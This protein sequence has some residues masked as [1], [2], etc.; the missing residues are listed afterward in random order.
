[1]SRIGTTKKATYQIIEGALRISG[2]HL[3]RLAN[4]GGAGPD[5]TD[6]TVVDG[7]V[8]AVIVWSPSVS[9]G[10]RAVWQ[11]QAPALAFTLFWIS[12]WRSWAVVIAWV[13]VVFA[14]A[15]GEKGISGWGSSGWF[16]L[17]SASMFFMP[18]L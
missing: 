7:A 6:G 15:S 18:L 17:I 8:G 3:R 1:M 5:V 13:G 16:S 14:L 11:A 4:V 12:T 2:P 9:K 10:R